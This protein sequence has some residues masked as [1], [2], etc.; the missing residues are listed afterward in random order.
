MR[1]VKA[2][3]AKNVFVTQGIGGILYKKLFNSMKDEFLKVFK[4]TTYENL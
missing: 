4:A 2:F 3:I 1:M